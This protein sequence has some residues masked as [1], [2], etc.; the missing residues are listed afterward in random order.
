MHAKKG[1]KR[2]KFIFDGFLYKDAEEIA[3]FT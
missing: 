3:A 1:A 2:T